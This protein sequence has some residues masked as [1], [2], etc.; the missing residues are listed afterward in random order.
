MRNKMS[1]IDF[2]LQKYDGEFKAAGMERLERAA[3]A[4]RDAARQKIKV[5]SITRPQRK[6]FIFE[7]HRRPSQSALW[8]ERHPGEMRDTIRTV[9]RRDESLN[10]DASRDNVRVYAG[11][12]A[13]WWATQMEFGRGKWK[14]GAKPFL[15]PALW[16]SESKVRSI[17]EGR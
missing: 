3:N 12:F 7:H 17:I 15:R 5:G 9:R 10:F 11:N 2:N 16:G 4:I 8:T 6:Y 13:D 14:G 1:R